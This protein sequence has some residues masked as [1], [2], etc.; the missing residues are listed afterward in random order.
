MFTLT[1]WTVYLFSFFLSAYI[2]I[3]FAKLLYYLPCQCSFTLWTIQRVPSGFQ[4]LRVYLYFRSVS[5]I[6]MFLIFVI[7]KGITFWT[8]LLI[9]IFFSYRRHMTNS[10]SRIIPLL[11]LM[12]LVIHPFLYWFLDECVS[13]LIKT[14][15]S[16]Y[17]L[18]N[19]RQF[20]SSSNVFHVT[21]PSNRKS[22]W[23]KLYSIYSFVALFSV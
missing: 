2:N 8:G 10:T 9:N 1:L 16:Q 13:S 11:P 17:R 19:W 22:D 7:S 5:I 6:V 15:S 21:N 20:H 4:K 12:I 3:T 14:R 23:D 18:C